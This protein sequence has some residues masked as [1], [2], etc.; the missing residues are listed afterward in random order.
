VASVKHVTCELGTLDHPASAPAREEL[1]AIVRRVHERAE[2]WLRRHGY[3]DERSLAERSNEPPLPPQTRRRPRAI[4]APHSVP[5]LLAGDD[6][7]TTNE[8][9]GPRLTADELTIYFSSR[10]LY[11]DSGNASGLFVAHRSSRMA[12]FD[13]PVPLMTLDPPGGEGDFEPTTNTELTLSVERLTPRS[14]PS[15][16]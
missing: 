1:D 16:R 9:G 3:V 12:A 14:G 8:E 2:I 11:P 15:A 5:V 13:A 4:R 7:N 6:L 10:R